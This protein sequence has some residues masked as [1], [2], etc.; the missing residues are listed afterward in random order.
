MFRILKIGSAFIGIIVGAGFASGQEILQYFTSFGHLGTLAAIVSTALFAYLGMT[1]TK[2]GSRLQTNS[3]KNAIYEI[4]GRFLGIIVDAIIVFTLFGVGVV[5]IAGAGSTLNQQFGLAPFV[6]SLILV[7]LLILTMM[8]KVDKVVAVIGSITPFLIL[9]LIIISVYSLFT[10]DASFNELN[11]IA[12]QQ[13]SS[14]PNWFISAINYVSFNIAV[15]A[16]MAIVMGGAE[17][18]EKIASLG[19]LVGGLGI[20]VLIILAHLA[21]FS[22]VDVVAAYDLPLLKIVEEISPVLGIFM[23]LVLFGMI[24]NTAVSMFYAF[25]ARFFEMGTKKAYLA[26]VVTLVVGFIAS[27]VGFTTLVSKFYSTIG[28]L[29]LFLIFALIYAPFKLAKNAKN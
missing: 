23:S 9:A 24:F 6:G 8:L 19:G 26:T 7:V 10:M 5:M 27:F 21:I 15:G 20:G 29:G 4:S 3:H 25:V 13:E 16:G 18:D 11:P 1:L 14:M 2:V 28:Y 22:K 12:Q 17:K